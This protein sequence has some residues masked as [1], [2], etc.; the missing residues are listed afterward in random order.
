MDASRCSRFR[1]CCSTVKLSDAVAVV[2][3]TVEA[4]FKAR[5]ALKVTWKGGA[6]AGYDSERALGEYAAR[7][8]NLDEKGLV[9]RN[10]GDAAEA[11]GKAAR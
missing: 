8:R 6:T 5:G 9:Y 1:A 10:R 11:I 7:A 3:S 2:G 4:V